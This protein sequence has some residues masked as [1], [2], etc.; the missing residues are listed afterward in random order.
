M[1]LSQA[2][3]WGQA[4]SALPPSPAAEVGEGAP[5]VCYNRRGLPGQVTRC[6]LLLVSQSKHQVTTDEALQLPG[7]GVFMGKMNGPE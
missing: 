3:E 1:S 4:G 7:S 2:R 5:L 6:L